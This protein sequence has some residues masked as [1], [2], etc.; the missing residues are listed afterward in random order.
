MR[1]GEFCRVSKAAPCP[2]NSQPNTLAPAG[3]LL[4]PIDVFAQEASMNRR[5]FLKMSAAAG[6]A[7]PV[8]ARP[9]IAQDREI[10]IAEPTRSVSYLPIYVAITEGYF[11]K[12]GLNAKMLTAEQNGAAINATLAGQAFSFLGGPERVAFA[13]AQG[14]HLRSVVNCVDRGNV[15]FM[16]AKG[17]SPEAGEDIGAWLKGKRIAVGPRGTSPHSVMRYVL[18]AKFNL[19]PDKDVQIVEIASPLAAIKAKHA[20]IGIGSEPAIAQ[21]L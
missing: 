10:L 9:A 7:T 2:P 11:R 18:M 3:L 20:D 8:L 6:F 12:A 17:T 16:A 19:D 13:R 1:P 21:G 15:Y 14:G 4:A 5:S